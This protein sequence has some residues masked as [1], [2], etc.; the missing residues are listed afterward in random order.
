MRWNSENIMFPGSIEFKYLDSILE[1]KQISKNITKI[2]DD[3]Y[4]TER[5]NMQCEN[6]IDKIDVEKIK[7]A[8]MELNIKLNML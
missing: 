6:E 8:L 5:F 3:I 4:D 2:L 7:D 1:L